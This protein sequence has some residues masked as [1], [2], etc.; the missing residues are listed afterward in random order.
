[1][2][3][4]V[5]AEHVLEMLSESLPVRSRYVELQGVGALLKGDDIHAVLRLVFWEGAPE[6]DQRSIRDVIEQEVLFVPENCRDNRTRVAAFV[7][8]WARV[9]TEALTAQEEKEERSWFMP[10][11]LVHPSALKL[12]RAETEE[13]FDKALRVASR[14]GAML[15]TSSPKPGR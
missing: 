11:E 5:T 13:H 12:A 2:P 14:F 4:E 10:F 1:M 8:A 3:N 7:R 15:G 6:T 9:A